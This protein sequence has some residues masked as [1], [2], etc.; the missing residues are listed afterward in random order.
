MEEPGQQAKLLQ[1]APYHKEHLRVVGKRN[2][3]KIQFFILWH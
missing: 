2:N 1:P 3:R